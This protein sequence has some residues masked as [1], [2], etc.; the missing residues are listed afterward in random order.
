MDLITW[1]QTTNNNMLF[2]VLLSV[3]ILTVLILTKLSDSYKETQLKEKGIKSIKKPLAKNHQSMFT[4]KQIQLFLL[5]LI[6]AIA[7]FIRVWKF[8][9]MPAGV[10]QDGA[11]GAVDA[12][13]LSQ[14]GTDRFGMW[15]PAHF[16]AWGTGQMSVLLSYLMVPFI[17]VFGFSVITIRLPILIASLAA[18]YVLYAFGSKLVDKNFGLILLAI[19]AMNP[20]QIMESRWAIDCNLFPH[21]FLFG[22]YFLYLGLSKKRY[23]YISMVFFGLSMYCYGVALYTVP[24]FLATAFVYLLI[25]KVVN[26]KQTLL[27]ALTFIVISGP[28]VTVMMINIFKWNTIYTPFF[29]LPYFPQSVRSADIL[30]FSPDIVSQFFQN[31]EL[32]LTVTFFQ[33]HDTLIWNAIPG[34]STLFVPAIPLLL[35]G[36]VMFFLKTFNKPKTPQ[37]QPMALNQLNGFFLICAYFFAAVACGIITNNVNINRINIIYYPLI[38]FVAY[39]IYYLYQ[40][41]KLSLLVITCIFT[42]LFL[43]FSLNYFT[44][45]KKMDTAFYVGFGQ[46]MDKVQNLDYQKIYVT[47]NTQYYGTIDVS[48]ILTMFYHEIDAEYFQGKRVLFDKQGKKLLPYKERYQY[49]DIAAMVINPKE[50]A[51]YVVNNG[52]LGYFDPAKFNITSYEFYSAIIPKSLI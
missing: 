11:M 4:E 31:V 34:F 5:I 10:N 19:A 14:Y 46:S 29:T 30:F 39:G 20:W 24:I 47:V 45:N 27:S 6:G 25:K 43:S 26:I 42:M 32:F 21:F 3:L 49:V 48:E 44:P 36:M 13:A 16:T 2:I 12:L 7:I 8:G 37:L 15:L 38:I 41:S 50:K 22:A 1:L 9:E 35:F 17:K 18:L 51:V 23:M 40:K 52:E 33:S 28:F